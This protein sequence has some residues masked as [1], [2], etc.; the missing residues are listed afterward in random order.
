MKNQL[1]AGTAEEVVSGT[2]YEPVGVPA[3]LLAEE[4]D[5]GSVASDDQGEEL[6]AWTERELQ[7]RHL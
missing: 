7:D 3:E 1:W 6:W 5:E 2:D 4:S